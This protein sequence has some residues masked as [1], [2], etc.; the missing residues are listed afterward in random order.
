M[1][2]RDRR[3]CYPNS[4]AAERLGRHSAGFVHYL[5]VEIVADWLRVVII[6][7]KTIDLGSFD[8]LMFAHV[9]ISAKKIAAQPSNFNHG[10]FDS[11]FN[12]PG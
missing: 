8:K 3:S 2:W 5:P 12:W 10:F 6:G 9:A 7:T 11:E 1:T 4:T